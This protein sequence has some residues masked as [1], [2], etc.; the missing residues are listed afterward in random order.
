MLPLNRYPA[1][2]DDGGFI[3]IFPIPFLNGGR[4]PFTNGNDNGTV[5]LVSQ[6]RPEA[7]DAAIKT[8]GFHE[9]HMSILRS[10]DVAHKMSTLLT[11][12]ANRE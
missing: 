11:T 4:N 3:N 2:T 5:A 1:Q 7:Q 10:Q 6:L 12:F 9:D 8:F